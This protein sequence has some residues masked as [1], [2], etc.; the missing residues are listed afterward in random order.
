MEL[1]ASEGEIGLEL[2]VVVLIVGYR[3]YV[4]LTGQ[5]TVTV[6]IRAYNADGGVNIIA[7]SQN[8][9]VAFTLG[10]RTLLTCDM[11]GLPESSKVLSY[12]WY[13]NCTETRCKVQDKDPYYK[14]VKDTLLVDV[15]SWDKIGRYYCNANYTNR[16]GEPVTAKGFTTN[17]ALAG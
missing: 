12:K 2:V 17:I 11:I 7:H 9:V 8:K 16:Q 15:T 1:F 4:C 13:H 5:A 14:V 6:K 3:L 10:T